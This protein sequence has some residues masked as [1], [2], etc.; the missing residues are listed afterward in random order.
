MPNANTLVPLFNTSN[1]SYFFKKQRIAFRKTLLMSAYKARRI[2]VGK[3]PFILNIEELAT[4]WHFPMSHVKT[5]LVMKAEGKRAEPPSTLPVESIL[6]PT[7]G[8]AIDNVAEKGEERTVGYQTDSGAV[9][10]DTGV[11]FG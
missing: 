6:A 5:P 4:L 10:D 9:Y 1:I 11:R 7:V 2:K 8:K 3:T